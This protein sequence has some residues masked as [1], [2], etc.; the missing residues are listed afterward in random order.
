MNIAEIRQKYP[1]YND[2]SDQQLADSLHQKFYADIPPAE[3]Y[4]KV[5]LQV[6][7]Q[8]EPRSRTQEFGRQVGLTG[9]ALVEG[10]AD[11]ASP[12]ANP[13]AVM[14]NAAIAGAEHLGLNEPGGFRFPEQSGAVS[15]AL[16]N[17][18]VPAPET[19]IE[20]GVNFA[21][22]LTTAMA[23]GPRLDRAVTA[24]MPQAPAGAAPAPPSLG[25][26]SQ[27][28]DVPL[29]AGEATQ[30]PFMRRLDTYLERLPFIGIR[31]FRERQQ[32]A[33][34]GAANKLVN[35]AGETVDDAGEVIRSSLNRVY[36]SSRGTA[37]KMFDRVDEAASG[38]NIQVYGQNRQRAAAEILEEQSRLARQKASDPAVEKAARDVLEGLP[39]S[40]SDAR[41]L[42]SVNLSNIRAAERGE[43][44][45][46]VKP[47]T[48]AALKRLE[49]ALEADMEE[50]AVAHGGGVLSK[51]RNA[52]HYYSTRV[53]PFKDRTIRKVSDD[54]FDSDAI[55][56]TFI[57][58]DS[59]GTASKLV[60]R[61]DLKGKEAVRYGVLRSAFDDSLDSSGFFSPQKFR[62]SIERLGK[63]RQRV[64][65]PQQE[66]QIEGFARLSEAAQR[67]GQ[68]R[69]NPA[70]GARLMDAALGGGGVALYGASGPAGPM[71]AATVI[72]TM[73]VLMTTQRGRAL[74]S[75]AAQ[76][77]PDSP[78]MANAM[79]AAII[80]VNRVIQEDEE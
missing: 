39:M 45:G 73:S 70:T 69:E 6:E 55:I 47:T 36:Q 9:R 17:A 33:I 21:G 49:Q 28:F 46:S 7:P 74:L 59:R 60:N 31:G 1:Q 19:G 20:R 11:L 51:W 41:K 79:R 32:T 66:T 29:T 12:F 65:T 78:Q 67:A 80:E 10:V 15:S 77:A 40:F 8:Q 72:K 54:S 23:T 48:V 75:R 26:L 13:L 3:F 61:L 38:A 24:R 52:N 35:E 37:S 76:Y 5:G 43:I 71:A 57:R 63:T 53:V 25:N 27:Q 14:G 44:S 16:T 34:K 18:G 56:R 62:N 4:Q 68:F 50:W 2:L 58:P 64:F 42:R 30:S 22:R